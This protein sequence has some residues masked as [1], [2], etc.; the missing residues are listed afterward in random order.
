MKR[1]TASD[2]HA[3]E[4]Y[5]GLQTMD[6]LNYL[7][8]V[9]EAF[10]SKRGKYDLFLEIFRDFKAQ[11]INVGDFSAK[12]K[13]VLEGHE[14]LILGLNTF[15]PNG[16]KIPPSFEQR[17]NRPNKVDK[18]EIH[19]QKKPRKKKTKGDGKSSVQEIDLG[20]CERY[21]F[22][23]VRLP[24][25]YQSPIDG[26]MRSELDA[27]VLNDRYV[28]NPQGPQDYS[29]SKRMFNKYQQAL[30]KFEDEQFEVDMLLESLWSASERVKEVNK[31]ILEN[32]INVKAGPICVEE[33]FRVSHLRIMERIFGEHGLDAIE[34]LRKNPTVALPLMQKNLEEQHTKLKQCRERLNMA[35]AQDYADNHAKSLL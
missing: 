14:F 16:Y 27:S 26:H 18:S 32:K 19:V 17:L 6:A 7:R 24:K 25:H 2:A 3:G 4:S 8:A 9:R 13:E 20:K 12:M 5:I 15:L 1:I 28:L 33:H 35:W 10:D 23:Y 22:S 29:K 21:D 31:N 30:F 34:E 11:R